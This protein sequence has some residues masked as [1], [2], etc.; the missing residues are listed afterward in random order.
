[1]STRKRTLLSLTAMAGFVVLATG[2]SPELAEELNELSEPTYEDETG[3]TIDSLRG[4]KV[5]IVNAPNRQPC[6]QLEAAGLI[7]ECDTGWDH[8]GNDEIVIWCTE[9]PHSAAGVVLDYLGLRG[10]DVRTHQTN[11]S[12]AGLSECGELFEITIRWSD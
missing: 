10:F 3:L 12:M 5:W 2:S 8:E 4:R 6:D 11:P 1:M 7:V 9:I